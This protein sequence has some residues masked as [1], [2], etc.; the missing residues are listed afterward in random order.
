MNDLTDI[1]MENVNNR[2]IFAE[3]I[4]IDFYDGPTEAICKII[5]SNDWVIASLVYFEPHLNERIFSIISVA[6]D[7]L[8]GFESDFQS[9]RSNNFESYW[10]VKSGIKKYSE[11]YSGNAFLFKCKILSSEVYEIVQIKSNKL[12]YFANVESVLTQ[13]KK[14]QL[15]WIDAFIEGG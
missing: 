15:K 10:E 5:S 7:W 11:S 4:I 3:I 2:S 1:S 13:K 6:H 12:E 8:N 9:L 14:H